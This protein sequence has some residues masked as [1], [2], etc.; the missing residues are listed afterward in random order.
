MFS[1]PASD[2]EKQLVHSAMTKLQKSLKESTQAA[3][4]LIELLERAKKNELTDDDKD[5]ISFH[6]DC[7]ANDEE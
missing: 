6:L 4:E 2:S 7:I 3:Q 1:F 5:V